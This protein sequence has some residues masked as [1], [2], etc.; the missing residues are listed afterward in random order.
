MNLWKFYKD[1]PTL[2]EAKV[3]DDLANIAAIVVGSSAKNAL[4]VFLDGGTSLPLPT[5]A[6]TEATLSV[7]KTD[8]DKL[9]GTWA[10]YAGIN[11]TV[12]VTAGQRV[13]GISAYSALG[14][15]ITI[16]GGATITLPIGV[17]VSIEPNA[18][19]VAPTIIF[20]GTSTY[21]VEVVS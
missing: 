2:L 11:G 18:N 15:T 10:Y 1:N 6:A 12:T 8:V 17:A 21:F 5:G 3:G 9:F 4:N 16:N 19:L 20:T 7:I 13:V 14:G